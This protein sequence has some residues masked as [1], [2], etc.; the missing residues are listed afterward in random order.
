MTNGTEDVLLIQYV[1]STPS[2]AMP[3]PGIEPQ[4]ISAEPGSGAGRFDYTSTLNISAASVLG[5]FDAVICDDGGT[6]PTE[7]RQTVERRCES[8]NIFSTTGYK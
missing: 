6:M 3:L 7:V 4:L 8:L 5:D 1:G 2:L